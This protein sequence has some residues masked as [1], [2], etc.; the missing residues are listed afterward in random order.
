MAMNWDEDRINAL[1]RHYR[2]SRDGI[3]WGRYRPIME[4]AREMTFEA[5]A[6]KHMAE[7][8]A[9]ARELY[10]ERD[11][12]GKPGGELH[13]LDSGRQRRANRESMA[14]NRQ[15]ESTRSRFA[16]FRPSNWIPLAAAAAIV[17]AVAPLVLDLGQ[18]GLGT[19]LVA[20]QTNLLR[21]NPARVS[22]ELGR[23]GEIQ[24]GFASSGSEFSRAFRA[25]ML[26]VDLVS[27]SESPDDTQ[28]EDVVGSV[29]DGFGEMAAIERPET[30]DA[31]AIHDMG[32]RLQAH[33]SR[34]G[35]SAVFVFGQ[36][37][38]SGYLLTR[39]AGEDDGEAVSE[40]L[41][42]AADVRALLETGGQLTTELARDLDAL[43]ALGEADA[44]DDDQL[45]QAS[46]L[47]LKLRTRYALS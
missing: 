37:V 19:D 15:Q 6:A 25:G 45:A 10:P 12:A 22:A 20:Q 1:Y 27:L 42:G 34:S 14:G 5:A 17:L 33:Y 26:F 46:R 4:A 3:P 11:A 2:E 24:L 44:L 36:W 43:Q 40:A 28:L 41:A 7:I 21:D 38:E 8:S 29:V 9:R 32:D 35:Q 30:V 16:G 23:L 31:S 39:I 13:D 18:S 47:L